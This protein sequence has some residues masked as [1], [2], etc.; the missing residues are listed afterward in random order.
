MKG[1]SAAALLLLLCL[2]PALFLIYPVL[3]TLSRAF[4]VDGRL[5]FGYLRDVLATPALL[6]LFLNSFNL[7]LLATV[8]SLVMGCLTAYA[9]DRYRF[10]GRRL[11]QVLV[12][13]P[14][15]LPPFVGAIGIRRLLARFGTVNLFLMQTGLIERPIDW[16]GDTGA[17]G[18]A[19]TQ[20]LHLFPMIYLNV[21]ASLAQLNPAMEEAAKAAGASSRRI[22]WRILFPLIAPGIAAGA[23]LVFLSSFTDLGTPLLFA[24]H[25]LLPVAIYE[26]RGETYENPQ[27]YALVALMLC[28]AVAFFAAG[29]LMKRGGLEGQGG[30]G[31]ALRT[32]TVPSRR[33]KVFLLTP[34][35]L[36]VAG[37]L[38]PHLM[39]LTLSLSEVWFFTPLPTQLS[40]SAYRGLGAHPL[41]GSALRNSFLLSIAAT[42][43]DLVIALPAAFLLARTKLRGRFLLEILYALPLAVPGVVL[44]FG[45]LECFSGTFLDPRLNPMPLLAIGYS[46]RR[47]PFMLRAAGAGLAASTRHLEDAGRVS[48]ASP[49]RVLR[50]ITLPLL[51]PHL[52]A[53]AI[54]C[55][56]FSMIEVSESLLL[57]MQERF[58]P[59]TKAMYALLGR[60]DGMCIA[61]AL[62]MVGVVLVAGSLL[63]TK[64]LLGKDLAALFRI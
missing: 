57:A 47:L 49:F 50:K 56:S 26:M 32:L 7:A 16:L 12:L 5:T 40:L 63:L 52:L 6:V 4:F 39:V 9:L 45:Y 61:S 10:R 25:A 42:C 8:L 27:G 44:A 14:L 60:P 18:I 64:R 62:G 46:I 31:A 3:D 22:A 54:L 29:R 58:F 23:L 30:K 34:A 59:I 43:V 38:L 2:V 48:G 53:G 51:S 21:A 20:S 55:F 19:L 37:A 36:I 11:L 28:L 1:R 33:A 24:V 13:F 17:L 15:L 41:T 35:A